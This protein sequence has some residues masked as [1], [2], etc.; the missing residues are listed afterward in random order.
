MNNRDLAALFTLLVLAEFVACG[1]T[2]EGTGVPDRCRLPAESGPCLAYGPSYYHDARMGLCTPFVYGGCNGN[3]NRFPTQEA[4]Q[5]ACDGGTLNFDA[6]S[7]P[8]DCVLASPRCCVACDPVDRTAFV[9][10]NGKYL[11]DYTRIIGCAGVA[12]APCPGVSE[13]QMSSQN[14]VATCKLGRCIA[15]D[16]RTTSVTECQ[17]RS[18]CVLRDGGACCEDCD[19]TGFVSISTPNDLRALVCGNTT[20]CPGCVTRIPPGLTPA[21]EG[22][23]CTVVQL[24]LPN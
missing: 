9:A 16:I 22:G 7:T 14:F 17:T 24:P 18:D 23:R 19:G 10:L 21:C 8:A 20:T 13:E 2:T 11:T 1:E 15:V 12:C 6:C 4:C 5:A 3:E